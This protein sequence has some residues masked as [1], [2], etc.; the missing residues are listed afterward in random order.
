METPRKLKELKGTTDNFI[1]SYMESDEYGIIVGDNKLSAKADK[2]P[3]WNG[4]ELLRKVNTNNSDTLKFTG[5]GTI[6]NPLRGEFDNPWCQKEEVITKT[7]S[8]TSFRSISQTWKK[9]LYL[10]NYSGAEIEIYD[11]KTGISRTVGLQKNMYRL[12]SQIWEDSLYMPEYMGTTLEIFNLKTEGTRT[13][14]LPTNVGRNT[15]QIWN[16]NLYLIP[17][18]GRYIDIFDLISENTRRIDVLDPMDI[19]TSQIWG[20]KLYMVGR[21][22]QVIKILDLETDTI[23][24]EIIPSRNI[25]RRTSQIWNDN[26]YIPSNG[27]YDIEIYDLKTGNERTVGLLSNVN[28]NTCYIHKDKL[29]MPDG[30]NN[31]LEIFD[32]VLETSRIVTLPTNMNRQ[33][34]NFLDNKLYIPGDGNNVLE[35]FSVGGCLFTENSNTVKL[36]GNGFPNDPL[37]AEIIAEETFN[38]I[39]D[40]IEDFIT[41]ESGEWM[42]VEA[43]IRNIQNTVWSRVANIIVLSGSFGFNTSGTKTITGIPKIPNRTTRFMLISDNDF[44]SLATISGS[45]LTISNARH[46]GIYYLYITYEVI[47]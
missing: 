46:N 42:P 7:L 19:F 16:D 39:I 21:S 12:T 33:T 29:Y 14:T 43:T 41:V 23:I 22:E 2:I 11:S 18:N 45:T 36:T 32:L 28:R 15:S 6:V 26:L 37:R 30:T 31:I 8:K 10:P 47:N 1:G 13:V 24:D 5:D 27:G 4:S 17:S 35:I 9:N 20:D 25:E 38:E 44:T 40:K 3:K 34:C